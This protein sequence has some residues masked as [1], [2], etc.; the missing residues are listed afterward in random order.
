VRSAARHP[1][2]KG[3]PRIARGTFCAVY[4]KGDT[5][6]KMTCDPVQ[7]GFA[8]DFSRP[9]GVFFPEM[10]E[11]Y[12]C[13]GETNAEERIYLYETEKLTP[14][15]RTNRATNT[16]VSRLLK[17][18]QAQ[19]TKQVCTAKGVHDRVT[20]SVNAMNALANDEELPEDLREALADVG[21]F[22][23]NYEAMI[24]FHRANIMLR[25]DQIVLNDVVCETAALLRLNARMHRSRQRAYNVRA[26]W[27]ARQTY[28]N[29]LRR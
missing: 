9:K 25:G 28:A 15:K 22:C 14:A 1:A 23:S 19:F 7:Y 20:G 29:Q 11:D 24:D 3:L 16:T 2:L 13:I 17:K 8:A 18:A 21:T 6:L 12:F 10:V 26:L 27:C 4:D 5:V